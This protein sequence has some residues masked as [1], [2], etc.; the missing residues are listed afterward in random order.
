[1]VSV[2]LTRVPDRAG[3]CVS[4]HLFW[5]VLLALGAGHC[6]GKLIQGCQRE[7]IE[8]PGLLAHL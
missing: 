8:L 1:M 5:H 7:T 6:R 3:M 4:N 2:Y